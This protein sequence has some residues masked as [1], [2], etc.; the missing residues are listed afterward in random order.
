[1]GDGDGA[2]GVCRRATAPENVM[3]TLWYLARVLAAFAALIATFPQP[4]GAQKPA[5]SPAEASKPVPAPK[6]A[7]APKEGEVQSDPIRCWWKADRAAVRVGE[8]FGLVLT[9]ATI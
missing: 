5:A 3:S 7:P 4:A 6:P 8:R 9:C 1:M 2:G